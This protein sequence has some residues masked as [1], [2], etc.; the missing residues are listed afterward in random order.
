MRVFAIGLLVGILTSAFGTGA[1]LAQAPCIVTPLRTDVPV[2]VDQLNAA[3]SCLQRRIDSLERGQAGDKTGKGAAGRSGPAAPP[4]LTQTFDDLRL[5]IDQAS[6]PDGKTILLEWTIENVG[7][8]PILLLIESLHGSSVI[9]RGYTEDLRL[10][11]RGFNIC[12]VVSVGPADI[13]RYCVG[14]LAQDNQ[15]TRLEP[16]R[17]V[18]FTVSATLRTKA[19]RLE[20]LAASLRLLVKDGNTVNFKDIS[21]PRVPLTQ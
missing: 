21:F 2:N 20:S 16:G 8:K 15:W 12:P 4:E 11:V 9:V 10:T 6:A 14:H 3:I 18:T 7:D 17:P 13:I 5:G 19:A 1:A